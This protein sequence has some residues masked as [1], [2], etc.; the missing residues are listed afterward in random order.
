[1]RG[2]GAHGKVT[3]S[4]EAAGP[5]SADAKAVEK[6]VQ[7]GHELQGEFQAKRRVLS[8]EEYYALVAQRPRVHLRDASTYLRDTFDHFGTYEVER[9]EGRRRRFRLFDC[10]FAGGRD[11]LAGQEETQNAIYRALVTFAAQ[12]R[13]NKLLLLHGPNGSAKSTCVAAMARALEHY[14][15]LEEGAIY[16]FNWI[17]PSGTVSRS[18]IGFRK[19]R[20]NVRLE[21]YAH[22]PEEMVDAR[23]PDELRDHPL[24]LVPK[25]R[26]VPLLEEL[27]AEL[28]GAERPRLPD[29][30]RYGE[31]SHRNQEIFQ[32]LLTLYH[33]DY[34]AVLRHVQVERFFLSRRYR[35]GLIVVEPKLSVD[36]RTQQLTMDRSVDALP[37]ALKTQS[38]F[39][40]SGELV[41]ANRGLIEFSDLLKRP[42]EAFK[43]LINTVEQGRVGLESAI[44]YLDEVFVG[45]TNDLHLRAFREIPDFS[46]F[47]GRI[48][49]IRVGYLLDLDAEIEIYVRALEGQDLIIA[50]HAVEVAAL[51]AV[52]TRL[53]K[54]KPE[55]YK[56]DLRPVLERLTALDKALLYHDATVPE[57]LDAETARLLR[58]V[59]AELR[60]EENDSDDYEGHDGAS[61]REIWQVLLNAAQ[62]PD[63]GF[64]SPLAVLHEIQ[65]L[66]RQRDLH[67]HLR[68]PPKP[69]GYYD[70]PSALAF[71]QG[72]YRDRLRDDLWA[73]AGLVP[74]EQINQ[75]WARYVDHASHHVKGERVKNAVTGEQEPADEAFMAEVEQ[76]LSVEDSQSFRRDV[77]ARIASWAMGHPN[78]RPDL[79]DIFAKERGQIVQHLFA[80]REETLLRT[81]R[82]VLALSDGQGDDLSETRRRAAEG[83]LATLRS[84]YGYRDDSAREAIVTYLSGQAD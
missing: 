23:I 78:E 69:G 27:L 41:D 38:L 61:P 22:L 46:S 53:R 51:W 31:L 43:Y 49:L 33:G 42:V 73:A 13:S 16:R 77:M 63:R 44:L 17:F 2:L 30:L 37:P 72:H 54:P 39:R 82:D 7:V 10:E 55:R 12:G 57:E 24:L 65:E 80:E 62:D 67:A 52:L 32:S 64:L 56:E 34:H 59:R 70:G 47:K 48:D 45:S 9:A 21:S 50:P 14:C 29:S 36:A 4:G 26:R 25:E 79:S 68:R 1:M 3:A 81:L 75:M 19:P 8:F 5:E 66:L 83:T 76:I 74:P 40:Y 71:V 18:G 15:R 60:A 84:D 20:G 35:T 28:E 6:L 11:R 58:G